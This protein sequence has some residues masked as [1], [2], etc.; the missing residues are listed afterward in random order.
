MEGAPEAEVRRPTYSR[1]KLTTESC[2]VLSEEIYRHKFNLCLSPATCEHKSQKSID[3]K[4]NCRYCRDIE[5]N[6]T[7]NLKKYK[8]ICRSGIDEVTCK[9]THCIYLITCGDCG[10][11]YVGRTKQTCHKRWYQHLRNMKLWQNQNIADL[12]K[13]KQPL[14]VHFKPDDQ[15]NCCNVDNV[16]FNVL[17]TLPTNFNEKDMSITEKFYQRL[18]GTC[19][20]FGLNVEVSD[21]GNVLDKIKSDK[22]RPQPYF[23]LIERRRKKKH[24]KKRNRNKQNN[25]DT[26]ILNSPQNAHKLVRY[27]QPNQE[28]NVFEILN[29]KNKLERKKRKDKPKI[30]IP[31]IHNCFD[32]LPILRNIKKFFERFYSIKFNSRYSYLPTLGQHIFNFNTIPRKANGGILYELLTITNCC[33]M[34]DAKYKKFGHVLTCDGGLIDDY[35]KN[36]LN[37]GSKF[38]PSYDN[39]SEIINEFIN[40]F[41][42]DNE[43]L[44]IETMTDKSEFEFEIR[45]ILTKLI[46][47][48]FI[49]KFINYRIPTQDSIKKL[50]E[51]YVLSPVDKAANNIAITCKYYYAKL[52]AKTLGIEIIDGRIVATGNASFESVNMSVD[53]VKLLQTQIYQKLKIHPPSPD[54]SRLSNLYLTHKIHKLPKEKNREIIT[55]VRAYTREADDL[56]KK[57]LGSIFNHFL[58]KARVGERYHHQSNKKT[59]YIKSTLEAIKKIKKFPKNLTFIK[60]FDAVGFYTNC[61]Y[62][63]IL[64]AVKFML[65]YCIPKDKPFVTLKRDKTEYVD[66]KCQTNKWTLSEILEATKLFLYSNYIET[67]GY[68][69]KMNIG[70]PQ[71]S[72]SSPALANILCSIHEFKFFHLNKLFPIIPYL[73]Y[74]D[75]IL[76]ADYPDFV[77]LAKQIYPICIT[78]EDDPQ[79]T[80]DKCTFLDLSI[81]LRNGQAMMRSFDKRDLFDF[82]CIKL[83]HARSTI[84]AKIQKGV[85]FS[86]AL[87]MC[88]V[89]TELE[90]C[91][92][93]LFKLFEAAKQNEN[94][95]NEIGILH[96]IYRDYT[97]EITKFNTSL[98]SFQNALNTYRNLLRN[99]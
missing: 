98:E 70:T 38:R 23:N 83:V 28:S 65:E 1:L 71:G 55:S 96:K 52:L 51:R 77:S 13:V 4:P 40:K 7:I 56:L 6:V 41:C 29:Y 48:E 44:L 91:I 73:R 59:P 43:K 30:V 80:G 15:G 69:F 61:T 39:K 78:F 97:F 46:N 76:T 9:T 20:P 17:K 37:F 79:E 34:I 82:K 3:C 47:Q 64:D 74:Q 36:L 54:K 75:D 93:A 90:P 25:Y 33:D 22:Y 12:D 45:Q 27:R 49:D 16:R 5:P 68:I 99:Q 57:I 84:P 19:I 62:P 31:F 24:G 89:H 32:N 35:W 11:K 87:R 72:K 58:N 8:T 92:S 10:L 14:Y 95:V 21:F 88:R 85:I 63:E 42:L 94:R 50:Q 81:Y 18:L 66:D 26:W 60:S 53:D 2:S 67:C 86:E